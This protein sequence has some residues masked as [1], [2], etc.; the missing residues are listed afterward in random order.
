MPT[1]GGMIIQPTKRT[2][3]KPECRRFKSR[4]PDHFYIPECFEMKDPKKLE[5]EIAPT[6]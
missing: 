1:N 3:Q 6:F 2:T 4:P 5:E